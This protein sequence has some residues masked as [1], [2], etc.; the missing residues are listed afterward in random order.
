MTDRFK[1]MLL[2]VLGC[3]LVALAFVF[4]HGGQ[5]ERSTPTQRN[6]LEATV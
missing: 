5:P 4:D 3:A 1:G 6:N 2:L